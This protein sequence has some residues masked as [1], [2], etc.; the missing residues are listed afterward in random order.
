MD[1]SRYVLMLREKE[2][3]PSWASGLSL[4]LQERHPEASRLM[5]WD[6]VPPTDAIR[7]IRVQESAS[8]SVKCLADIPEPEDPNADGYKLF[9]MK[10]EQR[11]KYRAMVTSAIGFVQTKI[12]PETIQMIRHL[13]G[14]YT[15]AI[16]DFNLI[17]YW[18][19]IKNAMSPR[20]MARVMATAMVL[21]DLVSLKQG[22]DQH[23]VDYA[24]EFSKRVEEMSAKE[25]VKIEEGVLSSLFVLGTNENY[26]G[27]RNYFYN[28]E[29]DEAVFVSTRE[30]A[31][32][33]KVNTVDHGYMQYIAAT[34]ATTTVVNNQKN[35]KQKEKPKRKC[36][37]CGKI[38][39]M[40]KN[41]PKLKSIA[42]TSVG[43]TGSKRE[44]QISSDEENDEQIQ[45]ST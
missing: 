9:V 7:Q 23:I 26:N 8:I 24:A 31:L 25:E 15:Q 28:K 10:M 5:M 11:S 14:G 3:Y 4:M 18:E 38:D 13:E 42:A 17:N 33:W 6:E 16:T 40:M 36:F 27:F 12:A 35:K 30:E 21:R 44:N 22:M 29:D 20:G 1:T 37:A 19:S 32:R 41:C 45:S 2:Q 43:S 34:A 39:H